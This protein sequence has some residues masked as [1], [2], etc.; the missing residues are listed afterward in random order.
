MTTAT[1]ARLAIVAALEPLTAEIDGLAVYGY[2]HPNPST[3]PALDVYPATPHQ[4]A[5]G[6][7][8]REKRVFWTVRARVSAA[9]PD[10]QQ[11]LE[12]MLDPYDPASVEA[13]LMTA[14]AAFVGDDGEVGGLQDYPDGSQG[15]EWRV[16]AWL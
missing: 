12:R 7:D 16:E 3:L 15:C 5:T 10:T 14:A 8:W 2:R 6:F 4:L 1:D 11:L 9:D 13:A